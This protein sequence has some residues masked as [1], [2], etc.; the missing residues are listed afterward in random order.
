MHLLYCL[1]AD[2]RR[3]GYILS[4]EKSRVSAAYTN[5]IHDLDGRIG[6]IKVFGRGSVKE[7]NVNLIYP[8]FKEKQYI[9]LAT[10]RFQNRVAKKLDGSCS[11]A[12][13]H[14]FTKLEQTGYV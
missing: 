11:S 1:S 13:I 2:K 3:D 5:H 6:S 7:L 12:Q 14:L 10:K 9:R 8:E 4:G